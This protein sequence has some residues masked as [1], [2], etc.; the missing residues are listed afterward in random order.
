MNPMLVRLL[1]LAGLMASAAAGAT[2]RKRGDSLGLEKPRPPVVERATSCRDYGP[3]F[4]A[5]A[6][7]SSCIKVFGAVRTE[8]GGR[9]KTR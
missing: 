2:E 3:G 5:V 1:M 7:T 4:Q 6:G 9:S 8:I